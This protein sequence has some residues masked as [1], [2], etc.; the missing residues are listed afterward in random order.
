MVLDELMPGL[1]GSEVASR[2][3]ENLATASIPLILITAMKQGD[4]FL[5]A[6]SEVAKK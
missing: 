5:D 2:L 6:C 1:C 3:A 4:L